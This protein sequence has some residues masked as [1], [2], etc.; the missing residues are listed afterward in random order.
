MLTGSSTRTAIGLV[1]AL[2]LAACSS[3]GPVVPTAPDAN[4]LIEPGPNPLTIRV[5]KFGDNTGT[6]GDFF[7]FNTSAA[8]GTVTSPV[9]VVAQDINLIDNSKCETVW[10][11]AA[12]SFDNE[13]QVTVS[14]VLPPGVVLTSIRFVEGP[15]DPQLADIFNPASPSVTVVPNHGLTILFKNS[16]EEDTENLLGRM[17]GGGNQIQVGGLRISRGFTI[18]CDIVLSNNIEI[19]WAGGNKWHLDKPISTADCIDDPNVEPAPP[20]A[21]FDTFIGTATGR[22]NNVDGSFLRFVFVDGGEPS[23]GADHAIIQIWAPGANPAVDAPI[24]N[25]NQ[26]LDSGNIQAHYDQPH[27]QHP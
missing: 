26:L 20:P 11:R 23:Q 6:L 14:E 1:A 4:F 24:I 25:V 5:C 8:S 22:L 10:S 16:G 7:T 27:G 2:A 21:P 3:D 17:T 12:T 15:G 13:T 19:N 18:H 9:S